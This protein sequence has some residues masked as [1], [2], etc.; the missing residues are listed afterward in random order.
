MAR[1][2]A[3]SIYDDNEVMKR[4]LKKSAENNFLELHGKKIFEEKALLDE[5]GDS[6]NVVG[7]Y[8]ASAK[9]IVKKMEKRLE[10][11]SDP[12]PI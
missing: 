11:M 8:T 6:T 12:W 7:F 2:I 4:Y 3:M 5:L 10:N 1:E 9:K